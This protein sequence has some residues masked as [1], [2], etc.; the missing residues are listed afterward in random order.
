MGSRVQSEVKAGAQIPSPGMRREPGLMNPQ[1]GKGIP[2]LL[3]EFRGLGAPMLVSRER[4]GM[5]TKT[6]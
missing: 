1:R 5:K 3:W 4:R 6:P 2:G